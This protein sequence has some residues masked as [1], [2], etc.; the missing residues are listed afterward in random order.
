[1]Y[2]NLDMLLDC[3][4][5]FYLTFTGEPRRKTAIMQ[6]YGRSILRDS[7]DIALRHYKALEVIQ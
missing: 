3:G 6:R 1:M 4:V 2:Y 7:F 5:D